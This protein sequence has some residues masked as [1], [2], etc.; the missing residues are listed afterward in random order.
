MCTR[1]KAIVMQLVTNNE[2]KTKYTD[3][4]V[5]TYPDVKSFRNN[6]T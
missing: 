1:R 3:E 4:N 5:K 6:N 2:G